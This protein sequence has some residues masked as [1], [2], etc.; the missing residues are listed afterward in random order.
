[1]ADKTLLSQ[2]DHLVY[3]CSSLEKGMAEIEELTGAKV[4]LGGVHQGRGTHNALLALGE[5]CYLEIIAPDP[6]QA[7]VARPLWMGLEA[8]EKSRLT[9]WCVKS[10]DLGL[11]KQKT[12]ALALNIGSI[13]AGQ[14][15]LP[16]G[17]QLN[18]QLSDPKACA[19]DGL[20]PFFIDWQD[21]PHPASLL[22]QSCQLIAL[23]AS[24]PKGILI[25]D[26]LQKLDLE[27]A[28]K[29][30][31]EVAIIAHIQSPNGLLQLR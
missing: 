4:Q 29:P 12:N 8:L 11:L 16:N 27:L 20:L 22:P 10:A 5:N 9:R 3:A 1:M 13:Q 7:A 21:S 24:H 2:I 25:K 18:W 23:E 30:A 6:L 17:E 19:Y 15:N 26:T 14:R 28:V 31:S